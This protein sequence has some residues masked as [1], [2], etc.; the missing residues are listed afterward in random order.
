M[1]LGQTLQLAALF[2]EM[3]YFYIRFT[4]YMHLQ[5]VLQHVRYF[6]ISMQSIILRTLSYICG[7]TMSKHTPLFSFYFVT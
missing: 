6:E 2:G 4:K 5:Y 1:T 3:G 7:S